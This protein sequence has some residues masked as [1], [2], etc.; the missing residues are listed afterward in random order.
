MAAEDLPSNDRRHDAFIQWALDPARTVEEQYVVECMVPTAMS[1]WRHQQKLPPVPTDMEKW[2]A[3]KKQR[4][5]NPAYRPTLNPEDVK[6]AAHGIDL[7]TWLNLGDSDDRPIRTLAGVQFATG[8]THVNVHG[9]GV[10]DWSPLGALPKMIWLNVHD[11]EAEDFGSLG[12][13]KQVQQLTVYAKRPWPRLAG[14]EGMVQLEKLDWHGNL[15]ALEEVRRLERVRQAKFDHDSNTNLPLRDATRLPEMPALEKLTLEGVN[16]LDGLERYPRLRDLAVSGPIRDL[17]PLAKLTRLT[18]LVV[19]SHE[20]QDLTPLATLPELR[21]LRISGERPLDWFV[22]ADMPRLR[23]VEADNC[24]ANTREIATFQEVL[25]SWDE[26]FR[27]P[28]PRPLPAGRFKVKDDGKIPGV[29]AWD[30]EGPA[31]W[32]GDQMMLWSEQRWHVRRLKA[33]MQK[34][35][36]DV[37]WGRVGGPLF[38]DHLNNPDLHVTTFAAAMRLAEI[39]EAVRPLLAESR[40]VRSIHICVDT[41]PLRMTRPRRWLP[42]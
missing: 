29:I 10:S 34:L 41:D 6:C 33:A 20:L 7:P 39:V 22:L 18:H 31:A 38:W 25:T 12:A 26:D 37:K 8:A 23:E 2:Q 36:G 1:W 42:F 4:K 11:Y 13:C 9:E 16:R 40:L 5:L 19:A 17:A 3:D 28:A 30:D 14:W 21:F 27:A 15:L 32:Q 35:L 24:D